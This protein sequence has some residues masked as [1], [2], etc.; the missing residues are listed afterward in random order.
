[1]WQFATFAKS[2][3]V[4]NK[5]EEKKIKHSVADI[6]VTALVLWP[7]AGAALV[8]DPIHPTSHDLFGRGRPLHRLHLRP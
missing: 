7:I 3:S 8:R 5:I 4:K 1:M 2:P 6:R